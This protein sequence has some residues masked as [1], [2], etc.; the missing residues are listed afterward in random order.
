MEEYVLFRKDW[1]GRRGGGVTLY[2]R[3]QLECMELC[4][5]MNEK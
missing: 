4:P 2:V 3:E 1:P 5:G